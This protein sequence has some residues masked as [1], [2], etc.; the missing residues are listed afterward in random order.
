MIT[1]VML[2]TDV[3]MDM[4]TV[5]MIVNASKQNKYNSILLISIALLKLYIK[6]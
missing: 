1:V 6:M 4:E 3:D 5:I 2:G